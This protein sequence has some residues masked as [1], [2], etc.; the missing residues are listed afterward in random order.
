MALPGVMIIA[1]HGYSTKL[2]NTVSHHT[3]ETTCHMG[4][5]CA[6]AFHKNHLY[7][8]A[9]KE[10]I[11]TLYNTMTLK[12]THQHHHCVFVAS[13]SCVM[14]NSLLS[15]HSNVT[16]TVSFPW[17]QIHSFVGLQGFYNTTRF[18]AIVIQY[19]S[20]VL[21]CLLHCWGCIE[22]MEAVL[23]FSVLR[24]ASSF[25]PL[26]IKRN[27]SQKERLKHK[28]WSNMFFCPLPEIFAKELWEITF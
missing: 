27:S 26:H 16:Q 23:H 24:Q 3:S 25:P 13:P 1:S 19:N 7:H 15:P 4:P 10:V 6:G 17:L 18:L 5:P 22:V 20:M 28:Q 2:Q 11:P 8:H 14:C 12:N 21:S 9:N